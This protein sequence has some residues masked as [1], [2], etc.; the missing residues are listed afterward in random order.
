MDRERSLPR[1]STLT[2]KGP[3]NSSVSPAASALSQVAVRRIGPFFAGL[4]FC[5]TRATRSRPIHA[6]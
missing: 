5:D 4:H 6:S 1:R 3:D 2:K